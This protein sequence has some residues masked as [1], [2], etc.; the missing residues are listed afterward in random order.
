MRSD[1]INA[2]Q[3]RIP[4]EVAHAVKDRVAEEFPGVHLE[5][6]QDVRWIRTWDED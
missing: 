2:F 3:E 1:S 6:R 5:V 4:D